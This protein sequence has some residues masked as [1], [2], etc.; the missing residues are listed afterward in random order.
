M[1]PPLYLL[2][3]FPHV[4][5]HLFFFFWISKNVGFHLLKGSFG[6]HVRE[7]VRNI[8]LND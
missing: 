2:F 3:K 5:F 7:S 4:G 6:S 1:S 8:W